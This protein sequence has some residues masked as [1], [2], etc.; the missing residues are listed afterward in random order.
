MIAVLTQRL[1]ENDGAD[2]EVMVFDAEGGD[3]LPVCQVVAMATR[4]GPLGDRCLTR[5]IEVRP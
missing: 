2:L 1:V 3:Y 5:I 4:L